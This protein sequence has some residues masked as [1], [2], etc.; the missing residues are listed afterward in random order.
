MIDSPLADAEARELVLAYRA[1]ANKARDLRTIHDPRNALVLAQVA[2][3]RMTAD[4]LRERFDLDAD[5]MIEELSVFDAAVE[6]AASP[7]A[8]EFAFALR[9]VTSVKV[10]RHEGNVVIPFGEVP[11]GTRDVVG[12]PNP[13]QD[14][15]IALERLGAVERD[16]TDWMTSGADYWFTVQ[17]T[18]LGD[19]LHAQLNAGI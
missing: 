17:L 18:L 3:A 10:V 8:Q 2:L 14:A 9:S 4:E 6:I 11:E 1:R 19:I 13:R 5:E 15:L 12:I 7:R 16:V